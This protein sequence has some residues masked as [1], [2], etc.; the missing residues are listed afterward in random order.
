LDEALGFYDNRYVVFAGGIYFVIH[1]KTWVS[2]SVFGY[3]LS[4]FGN[5]Y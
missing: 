2:K 1:N 4:Q 5:I 3:G